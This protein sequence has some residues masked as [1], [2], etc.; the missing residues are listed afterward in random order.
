MTITQCH[1]TA[2]FHYEERGNGDDI[3]HQHRKNRLLIFGFSELGDEIYP[4]ILTEGL[5]S[6]ISVANCIIVVCAVQM[7][8]VHILKV[9]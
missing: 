7:L 3:L 1:V 4:L 6:P 5:A 8:A 9:K 2:S